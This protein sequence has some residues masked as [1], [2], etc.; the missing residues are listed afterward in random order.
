MHMSAVFSGDFWVSWRTQITFQ[1]V[2]LTFALT[3]APFFIFTI[4]PLAKLFAHAD[5]T[6]WTRNGRCVVPD[7]NGLGAYLDWLKND[8]LKPRLFADEFR[9]RFPAREVKQLNRA[10]VEG[11]RLLV[12]AWNRPSSAIRVTR[13]EKIRIDTLLAKIVT[14]EKASA[15]LFAACFPDKVLVHEYIEEEEAKAKAKAEAD[16]A[17]KAKA[18]K[19][20]KKAEAAAAK[21]AAKAAAT[22]WKMRVSVHN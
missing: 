2:K 22:K 19:A 1:I 13:A 8:I 18:I 4:G 21:A 10:V 15:A 20:A 6:A 7:T 16:A 12:S 17:K 5:A 3:A 9:D 14:K 11:E